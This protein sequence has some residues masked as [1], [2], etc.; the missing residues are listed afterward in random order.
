M[1]SLNITL[2]DSESTN[3]FTDT[4]IEIASSDT[5]SYKDTAYINLD[6]TF[7]EPPNTGI[8]IFYN[9]LYT[10]ILRPI[11]NNTE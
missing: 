11:N 6:F 3:A 8:Y 5:S 2:S 1:N 4:Q 7:T 10:R 9:G